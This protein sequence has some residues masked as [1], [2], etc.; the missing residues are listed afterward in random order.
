MAYGKGQ[1]ICIGMGRETEE[2]EHW[3]GEIMK[4]MWHSKEGGRLRARSFYS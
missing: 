2:L 3:A 1:I 4:L